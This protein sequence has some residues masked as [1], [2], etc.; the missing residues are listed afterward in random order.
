MAAPTVSDYALQILKPNGFSQSS[1]SLLN[2][3]TAI[4]NLHGKA[5]TTPRLD[6]LD[7][8]LTGR[9]RSDVGMLEMA[10][11]NMSQG[12]AAMKMTVEP[13]TRTQTLLGEMADLTSKAGI[14]YT[15]NK[16]DEYAELKNQYDVKAKEVSSLVK[17]TSFNGISLLDGASWKSPNASIQANYT[18]NPVSGAKTYA[19]TGTIGMQAGNSTI[20]VTMTD[21]GATA[22]ANGHSLVDLSTDVPWMK[23]TT[24]TRPALGD[25]NYATKLAQYTDAIAKY[26]LQNPGSIIAN[27]GAH[28]A[29]VTINVPDFDAASKKL[30]DLQDK[31]GAS[32]A[33]YGASAGSME[34]QSSMFKGQADIVKQAVSNQLSGLKEKDVEGMTLELLRSSIISG[35]G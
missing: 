12:S 31:V 11:K 20:N 7:V 14:A 10:S 15:A 32:L 4:V 28:T 17:N 9:M 35:R 19:G 25:A 23:S 30:F 18:T 34:R 21:F 27:P 5:N 33:S 29:P 26:N 2:F 22:T 1:S 3:L 16:M 6:P 13:L 8:A 24:F